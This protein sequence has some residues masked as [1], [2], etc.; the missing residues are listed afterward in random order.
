VGTGH[1]PIADNT[2][3][4]NAVGSNIRAARESDA[5]FIA[6]IHVRS[7]QSAYSGLIPE[8][9]LRSLDVSA[10]RS[11]WADRIAGAPD[12]SRHILVTGVDERLVGFI[13]YGPS[14]DADE[15]PVEVGHVFSVHVDPAVT[16]RGIGTYLLDHAV[17]GMAQM[18]FKE[19][20][21]WVVEANPAAR[22]FYERL[23]WG[24][25]GARRREHLGL[26]GEPGPEFD[27]ETIRYRLH[28]G[29]PW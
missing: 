24:R 14:P 27:V 7:F 29:V 8:N 21:L 23:R 25:D 1:R 9:R 17:K 2:H 5:P 10:R 12:V 13:Y 15:D 11:I 19:V 18:G 3:D 28:I 22:R 4:D 6:G 16:G 26:E 20:T